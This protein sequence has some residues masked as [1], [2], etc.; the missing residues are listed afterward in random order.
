MG[1][2]GLVWEAGI[3]E[4]L[5]AGGKLTFIGLGTEDVKSD[6]VIG[7]FVT[8]AFPDGSQKLLVKQLRYEPRIF[9]TYLGIR[10]LVREH[11]PSWTTLTLPIVPQVRSA[12]D[13]WEWIGNVAPSDR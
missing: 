5:D 4:E 7:W 1:V 3:R 11:C 6:D 2:P 13:V 12:R 9:K 8:V 10:S